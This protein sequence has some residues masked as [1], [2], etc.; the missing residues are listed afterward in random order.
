[1]A[2][3]RF[4]SLDY[5]C[6]LRRGGTRETLSSGTEQLQRVSEISVVRICIVSADQRGPVRRAALCTA[7][8]RAPPRPP[9]RPPRP[10]EARGR[11]RRQRTDRRQAMFLRQRQLLLPLDGAIGRQQRER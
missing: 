6:A 7:E 4:Q 9:R 5:A 10:P 8:L 11:P 3:K 1:M 2:R